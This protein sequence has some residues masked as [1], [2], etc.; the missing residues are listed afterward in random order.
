[1]VVISFR[2]FCSEREVGQEPWDADLIRASIQLEYILAAKI[3]TR[4]LYYYVYDPIV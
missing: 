1:M 4:M 2:R 3:N